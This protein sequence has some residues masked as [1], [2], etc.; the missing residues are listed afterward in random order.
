MEGMVNILCCRRLIVRLA[1][2]IITEC[3]KQAMHCV[4]V[5]EL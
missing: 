3:M 4:Q 1:T 2:G 5:I